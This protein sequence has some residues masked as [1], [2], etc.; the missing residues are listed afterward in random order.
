MLCFFSNL[1]FLFFYFLSFFITSNLIYLIIFFNNIAHY[2]LLHHIAHHALNDTSFWQTFLENNILLEL[3]D[4]DV[5]IGHEY[6]LLWA[7]IP[8]PYNIKTQIL[9]LWFPV[10]IV[11]CHLS[12]RYH[13]HSIEWR[14]RVQNINIYLF[15]F[16]ILWRAPI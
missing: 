2:L 8:W 12:L 16:A 11:I 3:I 1:N 9:R 13:I 6:F 4:F 7:H 14:W 5:V 15:I 10:C